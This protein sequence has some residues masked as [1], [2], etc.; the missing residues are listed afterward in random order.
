MD[1]LGYRLGDCSG[2]PVFAS[3]F[4]VTKVVLMFPDCSF[5]VVAD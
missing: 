3:N 2:A 1:R 5:G 4:E